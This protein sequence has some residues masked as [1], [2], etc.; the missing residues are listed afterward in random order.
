MDP[1]TPFHTNFESKHDIFLHRKESLGCR[2]VD[3]EM[4]E[5][6]SENTPAISLH[7]EN[8]GTPFQCATND[9]NHADFFKGLNQ[10]SLRIDNR[11][12][13]ELSQNEN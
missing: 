3:E 11:L 5:D 6:E 9:Q 12:H 4:N 1:I 13:K 10:L 7:S 8:Q 2:T